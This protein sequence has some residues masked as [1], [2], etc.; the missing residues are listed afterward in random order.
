MFF[1]KLQINL[2]K[3][4]QNNN[5]TYFTGYIYFALWQNLDIAS[6]N[7]FSET[8][9][10]CN[11]RNT[12]HE[13]IMRATHDMFEGTSR[14]K[15][16]D[17]DVVPKVVVSRRKTTLR[18]GATSRGTGLSYELSLTATNDEGDVERGHL[19]WLRE[20]EGE[21]KDRKNAPKKAKRSKN[22]KR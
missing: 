19:A 9:S 2:F 11:L 4:Y 20:R 15:N 22:T 17:K 13:H 18:R 8:D 12:F 1:R 16:T 14:R 7:I 10:W 5:I 6:S 21:E 3:F